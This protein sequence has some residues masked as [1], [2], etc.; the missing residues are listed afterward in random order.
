[1]EVATGEIVGGVVMKT[2][3]PALEELAAVSKQVKIT[4]PTAESSLRRHRKVRMWGL[5][6][7]LMSGLVADLAFFMVL[8]VSFRQF[9]RQQGTDLLYLGSNASP[10]FRTLA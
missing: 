7:E 5:S 2:G 9:S 4:N 10:K 1:M 6:F 8:F 3:W